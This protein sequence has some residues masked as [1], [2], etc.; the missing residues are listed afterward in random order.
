MGGCYG[1]LLWVGADWCLQSDVA[2]IPRLQGSQVYQAGNGVLLQNSPYFTLT[3]SEVGYF[4][5]VGVTVGWVWGFAMPPATHN[6]LIAF[7]HVHHSGNKVLSDLGGIYALGVQPGT[8]IHHNLVHDS[9]PYFSYG[10]GVCKDPD[11]PS[12]GT[13]ISNSL[14]PAMAPLP[15][16]SFF[17]FF[18]SNL[19]FPLQPIPCAPVGSPVRASLRSP[20]SLPRRL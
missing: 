17:L 2:P 8:W 13:H 19:L 20:S 9:D 16:P 18:P 5:H 7:N 12:P 14:V 3:H 6:N 1:W 11:A 10:H 4:D 15:S